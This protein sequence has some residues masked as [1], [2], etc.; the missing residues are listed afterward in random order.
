M[1]IDF[2]ADPSHAAAL[3][4]APQ[5]LEAA[6]HLLHNAIKFNK[7]GGM[8]MVECGSEG[9]NA[10]MRILDNGVGI[11]DERLAAIW[12]GFSPTSSNGNGRRTGMGLALA[13]F[14]IKAHGGHIAAE[15]KY[16][17]GSTFTIYL[18]LVYED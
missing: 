4:D 11:P 3:G 6:Q 16:G 17:N 5:L 7:I 13:Q 15:S 1:K 10:F 14:I 2:H 8:V 18:P 9:S 12:E